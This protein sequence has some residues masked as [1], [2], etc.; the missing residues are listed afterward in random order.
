M[1]NVRVYVV[2]ERLEPVPLGSPGEIVFSG[3][4]VGR[5]YINDEER[6]RAAFGLD[7][8]R[9]G[10]RLYRSGDFG[11]WRSDGK[12][13]FLGRRDAQVKI[14]GF[15]VEIGEIENRLLRVPGIRD[16]AVIVDRGT[17]LTAFYSTHPAHGPLPEQTLRAALAAALPEYM[18]PSVFH[19]LAALPLTANGKVDKKAL[20][21]VATRDAA[22]VVLD[23]PTERWLAVAWAE[24]LDVPVDRIG[25]DHHFFE[26]GG[27][28]LAAVRLL[29]KLDR[30]VS[31]REL[32]R[33]PVLADLAGRLDA[34]DLESAH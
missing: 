30:R 34:A 9:P 8:H 14:R 25:R 19:P 26:V 22:P 23:T 2:N 28:S 21:A 18:V 5:G 15:R 1:R 17:S 4:C 27:T 6:T 11:R 33:H 3:V 13:E 7:P 31:L 32:R 16:A 29:A 12:L 24:V 10:E 20:A